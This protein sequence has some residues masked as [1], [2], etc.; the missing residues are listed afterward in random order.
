MIWDELAGWGVSKNAIGLGIDHQEF[1]A[2]H[3]IHVLQ[4][5]QI[6]NILHLCPFA[7]S[8]P[9]TSARFLRFGVLFELLESGLRISYQTSVS[10]SV[11]RS[12]E[13][14]V[15]TWLSMLLLGRRGCCVCCLARRFGHFCVRLGSLVSA[16]I[17][18]SRRPSINWRRYVYFMMFVSSG[19]D[20][21]FRWKDGGVTATPP[22]RQQL[23]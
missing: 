8:N 1:P 22:D 12:S 14:P 13:C 16:E 21:R 10:L 15:H 19:M 2:V 7:A 20:V 3:S 23:Y 11:R 18:F 9:S 6:P 17:M 4:V 5:S